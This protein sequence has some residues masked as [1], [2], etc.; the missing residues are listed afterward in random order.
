MIKQT[1]ILRIATNLIFITL[2]MLSI[3]LESNQIV[4][5]GYNS[6]NTNDPFATL[7]KVNYSPLLKKG[8]VF[9][10]EISK[11]SYSDVGWELRDGDQGIDFAQTIKV[12]SVIHLEI[13]SDGFG[14]VNYWNSTYQHIDRWTNP[15]DQY[16]KIWVDD[17][18]ISIDID[19]TSFVIHPFLFGFHIPNTFESNL[20]G[21]PL[22]IANNIEYSNLTQ[23]DTSLI[24]DFYGFNVTR[25]NEFIT[26]LSKA[27]YFVEGDPDADVIRQSSWTYNIEFGVMCHVYRSHTITSPEVYEGA[28]FEVELNLITQLPGESDNSCKQSSITDSSESRDANFLYARFFVSLLVILSYV[29]KLGVKKSIR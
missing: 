25:N 28:F 11:F 5:G 15:V 19:S 7:E 21:G 29:K 17:V 1:K 3:N 18:E 27:D 10:W 26:I 14:E 24:Y 12:G 16:V 22:L 13:I 23:S 8:E 9:D 20:F 4:S 2:I 6:V